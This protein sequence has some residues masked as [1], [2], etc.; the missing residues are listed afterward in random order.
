MELAG[1]W[2]IAASTVAVAIAAILRWRVL[3]TRIRPKRERKS[4]SEVRPGLHT[5]E[6]KYLKDANCAYPY[7]EAVKE[8]QVLL[9]VNRAGF[10]ED[11]A[12]N[13]FYQ[14]VYGSCCEMVAGCVSLPV[15]VAGPMRLN[16]PSGPWETRLPLATVEGALVA[17]VNRGAKAL[18]AN[19][20]DVLV[21]GHNK[22]ITR[23]PV[24]EAVDPHQ[25][26][27]IGAFLVSEHNWKM[28]CR[29]FEGSSA[30]RHVSLRSIRPKQVGALLFVRVRAE[31]GAAMGMNMISRACDALFT[32]LLATEPVFANSRVV[33][34]SGNFCVD[35]KPAAVNWIEGR[36][37]EVIASATISAD[38]CREVLKV[39]PEALAHVA[40]VKCLIGSAVAG[41]IGGFNAHVANVVAAIYLATGQ[42]VAQVVD[43]S[44][45]MLLVDVDS[46][47][48]A[49]RVSL[50]MPCVE[51]GVIGGG[52]KL[53]GGQHMWLG[54]L[55]GDCGSDERGDLLA[56][57]V[58]AGCLAGEVSLLASLAAGS[59]VRSHGQLNRSKAIL[60]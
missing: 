54:Y 60:D 35:K 31:T 51:V 34:L 46:V 47:S 19:G 32:H 22:G 58:A 44:Q 2:P 55:L 1:W 13:E 8:R 52:T 57:V 29:V 48:G 23:G 11:G 15:G 9:G 33:A 59:L 39:A 30:G 7:L 56:Q 27:A 43:A 17:S 37:R 21:S 53:C 12:L 40:K 16:M 50:T 36:G 25:A 3:A 14:S 28:F 26:A 10:T 5:L 38:R 42:D 49:L 41:S 20:I 24:I 4:C 6:Q 45:A 18:H